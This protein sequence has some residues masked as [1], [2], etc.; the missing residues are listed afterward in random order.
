MCRIPVRA[1]LNPRR[2]ARQ[3]RWLRAVP[4]DGRAAMRQ[5]FFWALSFH[6]C[7]S[8]L[9]DSALDHKHPCAEVLTNRM[10]AYPER[11]KRPVSPAGLLKLPPLK[12]FFV[13]RPRRRVCALLSG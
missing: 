10:W 1:T 4:T 13:P 7:G 3:T 12:L 9:L 6:S 5:V 8:A 11:R 2:I